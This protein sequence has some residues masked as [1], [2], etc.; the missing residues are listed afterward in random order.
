[1]RL[2]QHSTKDKKTAPPASS[3]K[4]P[5]KNPCY[6]RPRMFT[7]IVAGVFGAKCSGETLL[8][9]CQPSKPV[10]G[11]S[12]AI[13]GVCL[14]LEGTE[15]GQMRFALSGQTLRLT[16]LASATQVHVER[17][18]RVGDRLGGHLVSGHVDGVFPAEYRQENGEHWLWITLS[19][20]KEA[21]VLPRGSVA[22][23]GVSLTIAKVQTAGDQ[24]EVGAALIPETIK[25]TRFAQMQKGEMVNIEFDQVAKQVAL[26]VERHFVAKEA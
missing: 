11:E 21:L 12:F 20:E 17:A 6:N 13:D 5:Q 26:A 14:T 22:V 7:G 18:L 1:M 4:H 3:A 25:K 8:V 24:L 9:D 23:S 16:N 15:G 2:K 19:K 10:R